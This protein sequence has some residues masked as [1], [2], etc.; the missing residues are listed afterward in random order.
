MSATVAGGGADT[1]FTCWTMHP[2]WLI[3]EICCHW[4]LGGGASCRIL[5]KWLTGKLKADEITYLL[6]PAPQPFFFFFL[7]NQQNNLSR[8]FGLLIQSQPTFIEHL[9]C[10]SWATPRGSVLFVLDERNSRWNLFPWKV[11]SE[12]CFLEWAVSWCTLITSSCSP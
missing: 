3:W 9:L 8:G 7:T 4:L 6:P 12:R 10:A 2:K 1:K 11:D 5:S